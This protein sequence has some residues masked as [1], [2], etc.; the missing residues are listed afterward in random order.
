MENGFIIGTALR[1]VERTLLRE[2][3]AMPPAFADEYKIIG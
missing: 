1:I 2:P 3:A